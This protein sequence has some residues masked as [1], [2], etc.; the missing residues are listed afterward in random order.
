MYRRLWFPELVVSTCEP[1]L[2]HQMHP[3]SVVTFVFIPA[4]C[5]HASERIDSHS[6]ATHVT[7]DACTVE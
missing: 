2:A 4:C 3:G 7:I 1:A 6:L 5:A